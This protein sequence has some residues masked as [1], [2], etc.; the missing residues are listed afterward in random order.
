MGSQSYEMVAG[1][2]L[3]PPFLGGSKKKCQYKVN[4]CIQKVNFLIVP[5]F[6]Q[7]VFN[8]VSCKYAINALER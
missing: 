8:V 2:E 4:S 5:S 3:L 7:K 1:Y 6:P